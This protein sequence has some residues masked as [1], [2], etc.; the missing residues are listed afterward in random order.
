MDEDVLSAGFRADEAVAFGCVK[1]FYGA[2]GHRLVAFPVAGGPFG[3]SCQTTLLHR[4]ATAIA[5]RDA[6]PRGHSRCFIGGRDLP[7]R[8]ISRNS[9]DGNEWS[10][11]SRGRLLASRLGPGHVWP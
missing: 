3:T 8:T 9:A 10:R 7:E 1:P 2:S 11:Y 6:L 5:H 4:G